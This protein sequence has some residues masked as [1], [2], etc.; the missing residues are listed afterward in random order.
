MFDYGQVNKL[1]ILNAKVDVS[2][3][4]INLVNEQQ[5]LDNAKRDLKVVINSDQSKDFKV[6]TNVAFTPMLKIEQF[7]EDYN[8]NNV[9]ILQIKKNLEISAFDEKIS[10]SGYLPTLDLLALMDGIGT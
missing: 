6:D 8:I 2:N 5:T 4:S 1:Q 9:S 7:V 10:K 3:D